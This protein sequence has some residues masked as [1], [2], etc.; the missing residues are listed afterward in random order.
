MSKTLL[1]KIDI[2]LKKY[3]N[4]EDNNYSLTMKKLLIE[5]GYSASHDEEWIP[6][7]SINPT[8]QELIGICIMI[9][10]PDLFET[11]ELE[12]PMMGMSY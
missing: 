9:N 12:P 7:F 10:N 4:G 5:Q 8:I 3:N 1:E 6:D 11:K 2:V